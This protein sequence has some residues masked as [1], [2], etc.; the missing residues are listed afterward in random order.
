M[1]YWILLLCIPTVLACVVPQ[2]GM[3][4][5]KSIQLC[6]D[7]YYLNKGVSISGK[8]ITLD[9]N[10]A[11][12]KSWN[13]GKGVSIEHSTNI[14]VTSCSI[15]FY[16]IGMYVRNS[17][18]VFL[19][20]NHLVRNTIGTRFVVVSDSA[21]FNHDVSLGK[22]FEVLESE[23]NVLTLTNKP[24][25]GAF[26][27]DNYCNAQRNAV[28]LFIQPETTPPQMHNWLL[29]QLTGRKTANRLQNWVFGSLI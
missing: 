4:I 8:D 21:T 9:C 24:V 20:D 2:D 22:P 25:E 23:H 18:K 14:T 28:A 15:L 5:T 27:A 26:C 16:N 1:K 10:D 11:V 17:T 6:T 12:L 19:N 29:D 7:V 13:G 3:K